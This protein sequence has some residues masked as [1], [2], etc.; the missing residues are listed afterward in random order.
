MLNNEQQSN[1]D[2]ELHLQLPDGWTADPAAAKFRLPAN[3]P[4]TVTFTVHPSLLSADA[5]YTIKAIARSGNFDFSE[6]VQQVGYPGVRPYYYYHPA[7]Y[8]ARGVD[9]KVAPGLNV[10]Y[11]MGTGD[12][13]PQALAQIGV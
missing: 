12:E 8:R 3:D 11:I 6:G 9:V 7:T 10:G 13:V 1:A 5:N 4:A 2:G